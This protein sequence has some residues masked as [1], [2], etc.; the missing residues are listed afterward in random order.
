V[1]DPLAHDV[2]H[3]PNIHYKGKLYVMTH[4]MIYSK[5]LACFNPR[6]R[7]ILWTPRTSDWRWRAPI[8]ASGAGI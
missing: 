5:L 6:V 2:E 7:G 8:E 1:T 4:S 3:V